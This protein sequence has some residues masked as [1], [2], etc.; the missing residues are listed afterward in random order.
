[1]AEAFCSADGFLQL[2][3]LQCADLM[4]MAQPADGEFSVGLC[5]GCNR[6]A[7]FRKLLFVVEEPQWVAKRA[8]ETRQRNPL[9]GWAA[10]QLGDRGRYLSRE[11]GVT[12]CPVNA[13]RQCWQRHV[14]PEPVAVVSQ[15]PSIECGCLWAA[16]ST[17]PQSFHGF[18]PNDP[19]FGDEF[20]KVAAMR[21]RNWWTYKPSSLSLPWK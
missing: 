21:S 10:K 2:P 5:H 3:G 12:L 11:L 15:K 16:R 1:M 4:Q 18:D 8:G 13:F 17:A 7:C 9:W 19:V 14:C 6:S 20:T